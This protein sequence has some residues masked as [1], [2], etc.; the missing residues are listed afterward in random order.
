MECVPLASELAAHCADPAAS[1][2]PPHSG[3][4][5]SRNVTVPVGAPAEPV[6]L[7]VNVTACPNA[8]GFAEEASETEGVALAVAWTANVYAATCPTTGLLCGPVA[9]GAS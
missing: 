2:V 1:V 4:V 5:P 3:L 6:T 7:A 8:E 9:K